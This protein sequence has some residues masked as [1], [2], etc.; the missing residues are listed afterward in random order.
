MEVFF[1]RHGITQGNLE[2]RYT[3]RTDESLILEG[4]E[5]LKKYSYPSVEKVFSSPL[6]RCVETAELLYPQIPLTI[7]ESLIETNFG[8]FENKNYA[9]LQHLP[10][11]S[12]WID[13]KIAPPTGEG[14]EDF[15]KRC[16]EGFCQIVEQSFKNNLKSIAIVTHGGV[17]MAIM[18][19]LANPNKDFYDWQVTNGD[20]WRATISPLEWQKK[21][22]FYFVLPLH[23]KEAKKNA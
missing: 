14:R 2:K 12:A 13:G 22:Q 7:H 10:T 21:K 8:I 3:G 1:I 17:I 15:Q 4:Y 19:A 9:E 18:H 5:Q 6:L 23:I 11:Y 16:V 20:G